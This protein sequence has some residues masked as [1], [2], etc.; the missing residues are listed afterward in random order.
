MKLPPNLAWA[1][2]RHGQTASAHI[3]RLDGPFAHRSLCGK[4]RVDEWDRTPEPDSIGLDPCKL[5]AR[6]A[7][8]ELARLSTRGGAP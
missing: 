7:T 2:A 6:H 1:Q 8:N 5:C 4:P 3:I